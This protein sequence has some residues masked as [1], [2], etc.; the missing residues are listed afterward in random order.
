MFKF[1]FNSEEEAKSEDCGN[2]NGSGI[3]WLPSKEH[4]FDD[5]HLE[6]IDDEQIEILD[7]DANLKILDGD[8]I[9]IA[10]R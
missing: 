2:G 7:I 8:Q 6:R 9:Q 10:S 5:S 4:F 3:K 1:N